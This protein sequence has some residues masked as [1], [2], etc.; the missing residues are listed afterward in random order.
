MLKLETDTLY[1]SVINDLVKEIYS[2]FKSN[3][4]SLLKLE[5]HKVNISK[6][7]SYALNSSDYLVIPLNELIKFIVDRVDDGCFERISF[8]FKVVKNEEVEIYED[9]ITKYLITNDKNDLWLHLLRTLWIKI[10]TMA[11]NDSR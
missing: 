10:S 8:L 5:A 3:Q 2:K 11:G 1:E 9:E 4:K 6:F 7:T